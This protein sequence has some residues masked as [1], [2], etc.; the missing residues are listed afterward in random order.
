MLETEITLTSAADNALSKQR[1]RL[2]N[3]TYLCHQHYTQNIWDRRPGQPGIILG[4]S[5]N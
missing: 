1:D 5:L 2:F 4:F 3:T